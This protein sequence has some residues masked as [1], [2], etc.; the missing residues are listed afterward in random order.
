[1]LNKF[2]ILAIYRISPLWMEHLDLRIFCSVV[3]LK[4]DLEYPQ[5]SGNSNIGTQLLI[6][7]V[8]QYLYCKGHTRISL[9]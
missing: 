3:M 8:R 6:I 5:K 2:R 9:V 4:D 7:S 1:M